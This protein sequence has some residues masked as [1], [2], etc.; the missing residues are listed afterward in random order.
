MFWKRIGSRC[1]A[2]FHQSLPGLSISAVAPSKCLMSMLSALC[3]YNSVLIDA[4]AGQATHR[5]AAGIERSARNFASGHAAMPESRPASEE[6]CRG[7]SDQR[8]GDER[9]F[10]CF[11]QN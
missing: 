4:Y 8:Y 9:D 5:G 6:A 10:E 11:L 2:A 7:S 1:S 3:F